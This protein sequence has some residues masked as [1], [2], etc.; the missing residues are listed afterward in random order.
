MEF[1]VFA[2]IIMFGIK[3][4]L[5][6]GLR[7]E[8]FERFRCKILYCQ[9][10]PFSLMVNTPVVIRGMKDIVDKYDVFLLGKWRYLPKESL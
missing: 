8:K 10:S 1:F 3:N 5:V 6:N 9:K 7:I 2:V 4:S